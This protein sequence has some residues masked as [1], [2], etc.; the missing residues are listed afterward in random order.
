M[1][2]EGLYMIK[3][4][5]FLIVSLFSAIAMAEPL[6]YV[7]TGNANDIVVIDLQTDQIIGRIDELENAHGL[8]TSPNTDYLVAGS[9]KPLESG[10]ASSPN[11]PAAV[12]EAEHAS[13]HS[14]DAR[15]IPSSNKSYLSIVHPKHGHVMQRVAVRSLTHHTAVSPDGKFAVAVHSGAGGVSIVDLQ[16]MQVVS[17]LATGQ[18]P[19]YAVFSKAGDRLYVSNAGVDTLS[20]IDTNQ[21]KVVRELKAGKRPEHMVLG[22]YGRTLYVANKGDASVTA[23]DLA[24]GEIKQIFSVGSKPHGLDVSDDGR[25]LFV[26]SKKAG[27]VTRVNLA[28][29]EQY[30]VE[31]KPAPYHLTYV[32]GHNKFYVSSRKVAKIWVMEPASMTVKSTID[33]GR[34]VAHQM[35]VRDE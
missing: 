20:E 5:I 28:T 6:M 18:F 15:R 1:L 13:H 34:G 25:W 7:P 33:L 26:A 9:M 11:K 32:D 3:L 23:I 29:G 10:E 30:S 21:W 16:K 19:N 27:L 35:V 17:S 24:S 8:S 4:N 22:V 12:S 14:G 2:G 31:L